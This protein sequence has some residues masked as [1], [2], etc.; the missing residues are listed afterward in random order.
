MRYAAL[1]LT[2]AAL[3]GLA[4][5][6]RA[7][8]QGGDARLDQGSAGAGPVAGSARATVDA[9]EPACVRAQST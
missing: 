9:C 7:A 8:A 6:W 5:S 2:A 4:L 3:A 1:V